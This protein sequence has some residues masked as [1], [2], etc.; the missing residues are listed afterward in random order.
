MSNIH[1]T[2]LAK[3]VRSIAILALPFEG[4][5]AWLSSLGMGQPGYADELALELEDGV[6]HSDQLVT[7]GWLK[8]EARTIIVEL[9]AMLAARSG[10]A[11]EEFWRLSALRD[12]PEWARV[13]RLALDALLVL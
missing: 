7:V 5:A 11:H 3:L 4:Q 1:P 6:R 9:D 10:P 13:R 8:P 12:S 2:T